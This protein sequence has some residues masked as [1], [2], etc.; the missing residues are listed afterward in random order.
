[1]RDNVFESICFDKMDWLMADRRANLCLIAARHVYYISTIIPEHNSC[2]S[3]ISFSLTLAVY[4][5]ELGTCWQV[6]IGHAQL[7]LDSPKI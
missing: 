5:G 7:R 2:S 6:P 4:A 3:Q 1:M